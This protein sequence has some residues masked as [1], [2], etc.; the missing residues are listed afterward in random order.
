M[1]VY[2]VTCYEYGESQNKVVKNAPKGLCCDNCRAG[3]V[4]TCDKLGG[5]FG[6]VK[7]WTNC[8]LCGHSGAGHYSPNNENER[9]KA[10]QRLVAQR[11]SEKGS[12]SSGG[13]GMSFGSHPGV[14]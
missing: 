3:T 9:K 5:F 4:S 12:Y 6:G 1:D 14:M 11:E 8:T 7:S 10:N 2:C 13:S